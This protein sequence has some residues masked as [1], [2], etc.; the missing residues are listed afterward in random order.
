VVHPRQQVQRLEEKRLSTVDPWQSCVV[1]PFLTFTIAYIFGFAAGS[2]KSILWYVFHQLFYRCVPIPLI[3]STIVEDIKHLREAKSALVAFYYFDFKDAAKRH[4]R[5][6]LS[7]LLMQL[8]DDS[9]GCW[10]VL[11]QLYT[12]CRNG[13]E[14]ASEAAL[15]G[16]LRHMLDVPEQVPIYIIIDA[17]DECP[18]NTGTP[19]DRN[20]VLDFVDNLVGRKHTSL[21][22]CITSRPEQDIQST[23]NP[24]TP[25]P[26]RVS[27]HE[28][29]GQR[30][31]INSFIQYFVHSNKTMRRWRDDDKE[32]VIDT[33][34]GRAGGS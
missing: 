6:L 31:D 13:S 24:L 16:C 2:G 21:Y 10:D 25:T 1:L 27:L 26:C 12:T 3:S 18:D 34:T 17:L 20:K 8:S 33:L 5:G 28:E 30:E 14:Q 11:H 32:L 9:L 29:G 23:L 7:S 4:L 15:A 19:S 22:I